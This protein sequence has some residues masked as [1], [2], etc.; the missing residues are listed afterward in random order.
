MYWEGEAKPSFRGTSG[1]LWQTTNQ[2]HEATI[3]VP[4]VDVV[5]LL[6]GGSAIKS[7]SQYQGIGR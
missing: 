2:D 4:G 6:H 3:V 5:Y 1:T 7:E